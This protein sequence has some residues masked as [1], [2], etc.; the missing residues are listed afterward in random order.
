MQMNFSKLAHYL[1][2]VRAIITLK[3]VIVPHHIKLK[4]EKHPKH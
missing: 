3:W 2:A 4:K 1:M